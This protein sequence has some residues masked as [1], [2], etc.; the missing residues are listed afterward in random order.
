[1]GIQ[2]VQAPLG[3]SIFFTSNLL[4]HTMSPMQSQYATLRSQLPQDTLLLFRLGDFYEFFGQD[5]QEASQ[6]LGITLTARQGEPMA[7]IPVKAVDAYVPKLL[8]AGKR[9]AFC[10]Q[11]ETAVAGKLVKRELTRILTPATALEEVH[12]QGNASAFV[13]SLHK[14]PQ[15]GLSVAFMDLSAGR[16]TIAHETKPEALLPL[17][18]ALLPREILLPEGEEQRWQRDPEMAVFREGVAG[19]LQNALIGTQPLAV[20]DGQKGRLKLQQRFEVQSLEGLGVSDTHPALGAA[21][22]LLHYVEIHLQQAPQNVHALHCYRAQEALLIDPSTLR[23]L[24]VFYSGH[25]DPYGRSSEQDTLIKAMDATLTAAGRRLLREYLATPSRNLGLLT[26]RQDCVADWLMSSEGAQAALRIQ[27]SLKQVRDLERLLSRLQNRLKNPRDLGALRDTLGQIPS[28]QA[29][30][31][32]VKGGLTTSGFGQR[33]G[34]FEELQE[35][36]CLAL[37]KDLPAALSDG[38]T[39]RD[40]FDETLDHYRCL[41]QNSKQWLEQF[42]VQE[43][44]RSGIKTLRIKYNGQMGYFIEVSKAQ[45]EKVPSDYLHRQSMTQGERFVTP[46]LTE[47]TQKIAQADALALQR[48]TELFDTLLASVLEN[49]PALRQ[50]SLALAQLDLFIGWAS[51]AKRWNYCRPQL[52]HSE[53]FHI[54]AGRHPVVE[55][56]LEHEHNGLAGMRTFVPN[57]C[58]LNSYAEQIILL[59]GPNMAGKSTYIRQVALI[60]LMAHVGAFVPAKSCRLGLLDR[61]MARIGAHDDL[62]RGQSTFMVEMMETAA[63]LNTATPSSLLIL[64]EVGRGTSTYDGLS[65]AWAILEALHGTQASGPKT[66]FATH[67][68]ELTQLEKTLPSLRNASMAVRE[69]AQGI[70][71]LRQVVPGSAGRSYG[72]HVAKLAGIPKPVLQRAQALLSQ[73]ERHS[74]EVLRAGEE[75]SVQGVLL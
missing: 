35:Q 2:G 42:E 9:V 33:L 34:Q 4:Y 31:E 46:A 12:Q 67:Y 56:A 7:G 59:T 61:I 70:V 10:D 21:G 49:A 48:E 14:G 63:I 40:A 72:L 66:L 51:L 28:I 75:G 24:N 71:F 41:S 62:A 50:T 16:I 44:Q 19:I 27:E 65:L 5:A 29:A 53:L 38:G 15:A 13:L 37:A 17:L 1:M 23:H 54:Q 39:F 26:W 32:A 57:D 25:L 69:D 6:I 22:A 73:L 58:Q 68:H 36:L 52:E 30:L 74:R 43:Q 45:K 18:A 47:H 11:T 3:P 8:A 55:Q 20:F 60:A 64:D